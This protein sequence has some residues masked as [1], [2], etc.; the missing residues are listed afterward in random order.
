MGLGYGTGYKPI[1]FNKK[2]LSTGGED[3]SV[4]LSTSVLRTIFTVAE[5]GLAFTGI[6]AV[7]EV[8][9]GLAF[10]AAN[11]ILDAQEGNQN[12]LGT[13]L[14]FGTPLIGGAFTGLAN[15]AGVNSL[16]KGTGVLGKAA[17]EVSSDLTGI[18]RLKGL[19]FEKTEALLKYGENVNKL[20]SFQK[21]NK[22]LN[23]KGFRKLSKEAKEAIKNLQVLGKSA[24]KG[25]KLSD[26]LGRELGEGRRESLHQKQILKQAGFTDEEIAAIIRIQNRSLKQ[27]EATRGLKEMD[28]LLRSISRTNK[29]Q[30]V[31]EF[32]NAYKAGLKSLKTS[33][34]AIDDAT[35]FYRFLED[36]YKKVSPKFSKQLSNADLPWAKKL[37]K[38]MGS[39]EFNRK[40]VQRLQLIDPR[41]MGRA[42]VEKVYKVTRL[43]I[44][45]WF[46]RLKYIKDLDE[47]FVKSGGTAMESSWIQGYKIVLNEG[48]K[49]LILIS[50]KGH[51]TNHKRPVL[52]WATTKQ[53]KN[54]HSADS[55]G[56]YYQ[57]TWAVS[58][59][60][61]AIGLS[62]LFGGV[63]LRKTSMSINAVL[64]FLPVQQIRNILSIVTNYVENINDMVKGTYKSTFLTK[65]T[66]S[67]VGATVSRTFR[68][69]GKV[70]A[71]GAAT[72]SATKKYGNKLGKL[73]G[74]V[75]GM[76]TQR[77]G[78]QILGHSIKNVIHGKNAMDGISRSAI[79]VVTTSIRTHATKTL[80]RKYRK[81]GYTAN[82]LHTISARRKLGY[83]R[84]VPNAFAPGR[85]FKG[86]KF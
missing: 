61:K 45:K 55:T 53:I 83:V 59:G 13:F 82:A 70:I 73:I 4:F 71:G 29:A 24:S 6:G 5:I 15:K 44:E 81:K 19:D 9:V 77:I 60:G 80:R 57:N 58:R 11:Q 46:K 84:R 64:A 20:S 2:R 63:S 75:V 42:I 54:W 56:R 31:Q 16:V 21:F 52:V 74:Q 78:T 27:L 76:E 43:K 68:L 39:A 8:G 48:L 72:H 23:T 67:F 62:T 37:W 32:I 36:A 51:A 17:D 30:G 41:D 69:L 33:N 86:F 34:V 10:G 50:F 66:D 79:N 38:Y 12:V 85:P 7:A 65:L 1:K 40:W 28:N 49:K 35:K 47:A 3:K 18:G 25:A 22:G 26:N 14:N